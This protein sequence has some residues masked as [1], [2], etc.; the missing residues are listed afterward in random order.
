MNTCLSEQVNVSSKI[1]RWQ[2]FAAIILDNAIAHAID[3]ELLF[4]VLLE[5]P[6]R[7]EGRIIIFLSG[8]VSK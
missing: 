8:Y 5:L 2:I 4:F 3:R 7:D 6:L 1:L